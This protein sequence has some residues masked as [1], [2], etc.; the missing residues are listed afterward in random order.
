MEL[1]LQRVI[2]EKK[3]I[4]EREKQEKNANKEKKNHLQKEIKEN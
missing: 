3:L 2:E 1:K 4:I